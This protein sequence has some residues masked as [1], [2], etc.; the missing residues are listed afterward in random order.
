LY[1]IKVTR[2]QTL[3]T[4]VMQCYEKH[5]CPHI[6]IDCL[7]LLYMEITGEQWFNWVLF[8]D[9]SDNSCGIVYGL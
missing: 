6:L 1:S 5:V 3:T 2:Y 4:V 7:K 8:S 9:F